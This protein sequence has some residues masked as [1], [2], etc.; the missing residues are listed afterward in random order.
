MKHASF[1]QRS[2]EQENQIL[3]VVL[4]RHI[5]R[6]R[7]YKVH[8]LAQ[9]ALDSLESIGA[10]F[11]TIVGNEA[12]NLIARVGAAVDESWHFLKAER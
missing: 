12:L 9:H 1:P 3:F 6:F 4:S 5:S 10:A 7:V 8:T 2:R 11:R